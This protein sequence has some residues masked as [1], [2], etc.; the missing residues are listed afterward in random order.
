MERERRD[1]AEI[2]GRLGSLLDEETTALRG[3]NHGALTEIKY[4]KVHG[5]LDV[6][7]ALGR[8]GKGPG[9]P[10]LAPIMTELRG[11]LELNQRVLKLHLDALNEI[12]S[13][14]SNAIRESEW[15]GTYTQAI[16]GYGDAG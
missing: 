11:K 10:R 2:A 13:V 1:F 7:R 12:T 14:L 5:C 9:D 4:R 3:N 6:T 15:D 16:C 8:A